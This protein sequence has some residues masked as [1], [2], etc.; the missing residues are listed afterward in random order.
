MNIDRVINFHHVRNFQLKKSEPSPLETRPIYDILFLCNGKSASSTI[1]MSLGV[2]A[3]LSVLDVV[4]SILGI[5]FSLPSCHNKWA[6]FFRTVISDKNQKARWYWENFRSTW[7]I[8]SLKI[9]T[10]KTPKKVFLLLYHNLPGQVRCSNAK[11]NARG[12]QKSGICERGSI[13]L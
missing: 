7:V 3:M 4:N 12:K 1:T 5:F 11:G 6:V 9:E 10:L 13:I 2:S 8:F